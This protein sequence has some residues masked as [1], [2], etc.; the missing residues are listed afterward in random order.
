MQADPD[1]TRPF[2]GE[3]RA[4]E[5]TGATEALPPTGGGV[6][7]G[8]LVLERYRLE[9]QIG[10]GGHGA[11]WEAIDEKLERRVAVKV[12]PRADP[13]AG[14]EAAD[15]ARLEERAQ[16]EGR[17]TARLGHPGIV[18]LYELGADAGSVY[19]VSELVRGRTVTELAAAGALSDRDVEQVGVALCSALAHAH[20]HGVIHRDVKPQ[21]VIVVAEPAAGAGF[22][23]LTDF[24]VAYLTGDESLTL[25]GDVV[26]TLAYMAPEQAEGAAVTTAA[27]VYSLAL[28]LYEGWT[29]GGAAGGAAR[30]RLAGRPLA[31]LGHAR[32]DLPAGLCARIDLA[33]DPR[34]EM[35]PQLDE[36]E[37]EL[38]AAGERLSAAGGL[39]E[40]SVQRRVGIPAVGRRTRLPVPPTWLLRIG[41]GLAAGALVTA[42]FELLAPSSPVSPPPPAGAV[43]AVIV[44]VLP[45]IGWLLAAACVGVWLVLPGVDRQ[46]TALVLLCALAPV[47]L[48]MLRGGLLWSMPALAPLLGAI[49]LAPAFPALAGMASTVWRRIGLAVAGALW[50]VAAELLSGRTLLAGPPPGSAPWETWEESPLDAAADAVEPVITSPVLAPAVLWAALAA[51]LPLVVRGRSLGLDAA[52]AALWAV[53]LVVGHA[54]LF[55]LLGSE[56]S[57]TYSGALV[58]A[59]VLG[60]A[61]AVGASA[62]GLP[63]RRAETAPSRRIEAEG[64]LL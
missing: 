37:R 60:A 25:T 22:A 55:V 63:W 1:T 56:A 16:R 50:L 20:A 31:P 43:A 2:S 33:L 9:H 29:G 27:D 36:L 42:A 13:G 17:I 3:Q 19:L 14:S 39:V 59:A 51:V 45:R 32:P 30:A 38:R 48:L 5:A 23:K 21:N 40:P 62:T 47:P 35:R 15:R 8:R 64:P 18:T 10:R 24:G 44:A 34:P 6:G 4:P 61:V 52:G 28:L 53:A 41:A 58:G 26:G 46:G 49:G 54:W 11:V 12:I 7:A 57:P